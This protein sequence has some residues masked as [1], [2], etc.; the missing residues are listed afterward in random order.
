MALKATITLRSCERCRRTWS[1]LAGPSHRRAKCRA[2]RVVAIHERSTSRLCLR[3]RR[4]NTMASRP[5]RRAEH[6]MPAIADARHAAVARLFA[7]R[8]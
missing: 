8:Q 3:L 1:S 4:L 6:C 7:P 2:A 5:W